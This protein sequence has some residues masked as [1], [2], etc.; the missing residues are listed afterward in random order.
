MFTLLKSHQSLL[1][2]RKIESLLRDIVNINIY[3]KNEK[4]WKT[5]FL[6]AKREQTNIIYGLPTSSYFC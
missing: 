5:S 1:E 6:T 4:E 3:K 2:K